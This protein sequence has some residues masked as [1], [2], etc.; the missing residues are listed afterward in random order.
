MTPA[1]RFAKIRHDRSAA[2]FTSE[3]LGLDETDQPPVVGLRTMLG[4]LFTDGGATVTL[5]STDDPDR[6]FAHTMVQPDGDIVVKIAS[7]DDEHDVAACNQHTRDVAAWFEALQSR[8]WRA[9]RRL[10]AVRCLVF[11]VLPLFAASVMQVETGP[12]G[13]G[14][15]SVAG[16]VAGGVSFAE[17]INAAGR[18]LGS[19]VLTAH[20]SRIYRL[21]ASPWYNRTIVI[22]PAVLASVSGFIGSNPIVIALAFVVPA[23]TI[24][25]LGV[26]VLWFRRKFLASSN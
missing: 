22:A 18:P 13:A 25:V 23:V 1:D 3:K 5:A 12:T 8:L 16:I 7:I 11:A 19:D 9:V 17:I 15:A 6:P 4:A 14:V 20:A 10:D 26:L 24:I 21:R 2:S